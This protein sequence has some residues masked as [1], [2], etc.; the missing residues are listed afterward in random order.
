MFLKR[1]Q[2]ARESFL[3]ESELCQTGPER[4]AQATPP[5]SLPHRQSKSHTTPPQFQP[6]YIKLFHKIK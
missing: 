5:T 2:S 3:E 6:K 4:S 1:R